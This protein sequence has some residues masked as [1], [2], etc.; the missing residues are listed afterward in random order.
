MLHSVYPGYT[1]Q[2]VLD[3]MEFTPRVPESAPFTAE[4]TAEELHLLQ[5]VV[6]EKVERG[7]S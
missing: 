4:P 3:S 6:R 1:V 2:N 5:A 7:L